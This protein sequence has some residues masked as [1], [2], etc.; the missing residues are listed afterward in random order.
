MIAGLFV[1]SAKEFAALL[2]HLGKSADAEKILN[3]A[4]EMSEAVRKHGRDPQWY[5]RAYDAF[6]EK[7]GSAECE[8][9]QIFIES[10]AWCT[11]AQIGAEDGF[12]KSA[13]DSVNRY[14]ATNHGLLLQ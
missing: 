12:D 3:D 11:M 6:G 9:G 2:K 13:L 5:L 1:Y 14:L 10:N 7:I 8:D 4:S